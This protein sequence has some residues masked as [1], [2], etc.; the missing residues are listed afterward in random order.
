MYPVAIT[1]FVYLVHVL[2][3]LSACSEG[4]SS[5]KARED[6]NPGASM[7]EIM[8]AMNFGVRRRSRK[9]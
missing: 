4:T 8:E 1:G 6:N 3:N 5:K 9:V 2:L 7:A